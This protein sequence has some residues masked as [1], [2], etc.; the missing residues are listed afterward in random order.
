MYN[1]SYW[2]LDGTRKFA[3]RSNHT[4]L[5]GGVFKFTDLKIASFNMT[6]DYECV[7]ERENSRG[8]KIVSQKALF[9][10]LKGLWM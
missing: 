8:Q 3:I 4:N 2:L 1:Y 10:E 7:I 9:S 6:G 5:V